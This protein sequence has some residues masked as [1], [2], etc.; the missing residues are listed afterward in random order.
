MPWR[1]CSDTRSGTA[2]A[3]TLLPLPQAVCADSAR[4]PTIPTLF[5]AQ[6]LWQPAGS[7]ATPNPAA[8]AR[9]AA[10]GSRERQRPQR[11]LR[12]HSPPCP[13]GPLSSGFRT[14]ARDSK[15]LASRAQLSS[16]PQRTGRSGNARSVCRHPPAGP[17]ARPGPRLAARPG[18]PSLLRFTA[19]MLRGPVLQAATS[20]WSSP[21]AC[22]R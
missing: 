12:Q 16:I 18:A 7:H 22:R 2:G 1:C 15:R 14:T 3:A 11:S 4:P 17:P 21:T 8:H 6:C 20:C 9:P 13:T 5:G 19:F 10:A